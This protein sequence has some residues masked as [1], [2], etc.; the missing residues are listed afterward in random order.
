MLIAIG[1]EISFKA[2]D[3]IRLVEAED[4]TS[5]PLLLV[6][7]PALDRSNLKVQP[8]EIGK[9]FNFATTKSNRSR[10]SSIAS[11]DVLYTLLDL[12]NS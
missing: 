12:Q 4:S 7:L 5:R 1:W 10:L 6:L 11:F 3:H 2:I 8:V 9:S